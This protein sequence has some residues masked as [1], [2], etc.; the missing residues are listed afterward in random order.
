MEDESVTS[1]LTNGKGNK[2]R[3]MDS[4]GKL[5]SLVYVSSTMLVLEFVPYSNFII[6]QWLN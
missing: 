4:A 6:S 1:P 5:V 3:I 2:Q